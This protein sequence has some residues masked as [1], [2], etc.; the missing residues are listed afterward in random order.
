MR[1]MR[2]SGW[3]IGVMAGVFSFASA[4]SAQPPGVMQAP[5]PTPVTSGPGRIVLS[6]VVAA[7]YREAVV[8]VAKKPTISTRGTFP[9]FTCTPAVFEWLLEHPDRVSLA[10]QRL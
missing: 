2:M 8:A 6:E 1:P 10:W 4:A 3:Q 7:P 5:M 9:E